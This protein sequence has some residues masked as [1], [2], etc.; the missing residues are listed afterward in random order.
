VGDLVQADDGFRAPSRVTRAPTRVLVYAVHAH[1][2]HRPRPVV[3]PA[4]LTA[5]ADPEIKVAGS[6]PLL[7]LSHSASVTVAEVAFLL[8]MIA[9][10]WIAVAW[11]LWDRP[12]PGGSKWNRFRMI[13]A[14][15]LIAVGGL[16][17]IIA[18]YGGHLF[19]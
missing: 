6:E 19:T 2:P 1:P 18:S 15:T 16:L 5:P 8:F 9:G 10:V 3:G 14:G 12:G 4:D 17:L 7:A 11:L 13:V